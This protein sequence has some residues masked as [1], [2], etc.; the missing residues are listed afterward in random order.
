MAKKPTISR[1]EQLRR[2]AVARGAAIAFL[3]SRDAHYSGK[4]LFNSMSN[5][6]EAIEYTQANMDYILHALANSELIGSSKDGNTNVYFKK[7]L[8]PQ[9]DPQELVAKTAKVAKTLVVT[10]DIKIDLVKATGRIR[11]TIQGISIDIGVI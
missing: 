5:K 3:N 4:E 7:G 9:T 8:M 6:L 11:M 10:P 1:T 2:A